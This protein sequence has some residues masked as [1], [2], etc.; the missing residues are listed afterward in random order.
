MKRL[1]ASIALRDV[2][3]MVGDAKTRWT[4]EQKAAIKVLL[5][6]YLRAHV[7]YCGYCPDNC[8]FSDELR[9]VTS[10]AS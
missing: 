4:A 9:E 1:A 10:D 8:E 2:A 5:R 7:R 6:R 3:D